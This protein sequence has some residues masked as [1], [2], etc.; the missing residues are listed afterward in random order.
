MA[1]DADVVNMLNTGHARAVAA[2]TGVEAGIAA[3]LNQLS[4]QIA[5][6]NHMDTRLMNG[7][8]ADQ[9][10]QQQVVQAKEAYTTPLSPMAAP[11]ATPVTTK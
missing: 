3:V 11:L 4:L 6:A 7:F 10:F 2:S 9:L 5:S 8:L 1:M